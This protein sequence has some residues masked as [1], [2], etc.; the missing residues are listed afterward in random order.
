MTVALISELHRLQPAQF[1]GGE[2]T[3]VAL[4]PGRILN[5]LKG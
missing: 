1:V 5:F 4:S 3:H 2:E